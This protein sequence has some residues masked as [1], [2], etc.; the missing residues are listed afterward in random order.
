[1]PKKL[2]TSSNQRVDLDDFLRASNEYTAETIEFHRNRLWQAAKAVVASGFRIEIADQTANPGEFTVYNGVALNKDGAVLN[3]E[4]QENDSRTYTLSGTN[5]SFYIEIEFVE[6]TSDVDTRAFWDPTFSGNTPNGKEFDLNA[7]TRVTPDWQLVTPVSTTG[8]DVDTNINT[9]KIPIALFQTNGSNEITGA[10]T[11]APSSNLAVDTLVASSSLELIDTTIFP[12]TGTIVFPSTAESIAYN[13]ND[14]VNNILTLS[15]PTGNAYD[16]GVIVQQDGVVPDML[17]ESTDPAPTT[18]SDRRRSFFKG[19]ENRGAALTAS[20]ESATARDD[21]DLQS[22]KD[23]IDFYA[24]QLREMKWGNLRSDKSGITVPPLSFTDTRYYDAAGSIQGAKQSLITIG[25]GSYTYGDL[26]STS[27]DLGTIIQQAHDALDATNGG[28]IYVKAGD[29]VWDAA[30]TVDRPFS[31]EFDKGVNFVAGTYTTY[32]IFPGINNVS[33]EI[34]GMPAGPTTSDLLGIADFTGYAVDLTLKD[35]TIGYLSLTLGG[36][37]TTIIA[38]NCDFLDTGLDAVQMGVTRRTELSVFRNCRFLYV[39]ESSDSPRQL[40]S[41]CSDT[42]F[43]DCIFDLSNAAAFSK[44]KFVNQNMTSIAPGRMTFDRCSFLST[45]TGKAV[46]P[47]RFVSSTFFPGID[48]IAFRDCIFDFEFGTTAN[49]TDRTVLNFDISSGAGTGPMKNIL[50]ENCDFSGI[51]ENNTIAGTSIVDPYR[52]VSFVSQAPVYNVVVNNC[53]FGKEINPAGATSTLPNHYTEFVYLGI[54]S[55]EGSGVTISNN[56]FSTFSRA[57][58]VSGDGA[59]SVVGNYFRQKAQTAP[60]GDTIQ[61]IYVIGVQEQALISGNQIDML[62]F[63]TGASDAVIG[64]FVTE[65]TNVTIVDNRIRVFDFYTVVA[66]ATVYGIWGSTSADPTQFIVTGNHVEAVSAAKAIQPIDIS[67]SS[68]TTS[69]IVVSDNIVSAQALSVSI[70]NKMVGIEIVSDTIATSPSP[71]SVSG[72]C[73]RFDSGGV[74]VTLPVYGISIF[75]DHVTVVGN[76]I[77]MDD[78]GATEVVG[79]YSSSSEYLTI[80][81]NHVSIEDSAAG[82][83]GIRGIQLNND[84]SY[85]N[86][87]GNTIYGEQ[88]MLWCIEVDVGSISEARSIT[89]ANNVMDGSCD[90]TVSKHGGIHFVTTNVTVGDCGAWNITGNS[91]YERISNAGDADRKAIYVEG[92]LQVR[93]VNVIGNSNG[94]TFTATNRSSDIE[95]DTCSYV[96]VSN[97]ICERVASNSGSIRI[98]LTACNSITLNGNNVPYSAAIGFGAST[99]WITG[100]ISGLYNNNQSVGGGILINGGAADMLSGGSNHFAVGVLA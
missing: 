34:I 17:V 100:G 9:V 62:T 76:S 67:T 23:Q 78:V 82:L 32:A 51:D 33:M 80:S 81:G 24:A 3:N 46:E 59:F 56:S 10:T 93:A 75:G 58:N 90:E 31:L 83:N 85:S 88:D 65:G 87:S 28:S 94:D 96:N 36:A 18:G 84:C 95:V 50:I 2:N 98:T 66:T 97:N 69:A 26:N 52:A 35:C 49:V 54:T 14:R 7:A 16:L 72:N 25:D 6:S 77:T 70:Y 42:T 71:V 13:N 15:V 60:F 43:E 40:I 73:V 63:E 8:F 47:F 91:F 64:I 74:A 30:V 29:Y 5:L 11:S 20:K 99:L 61:A 4:A 21:L 48:G 37:D 57:V 86:I 39:N 44:E 92:T 45:N 22:L 55:T 53:K 68:G 19:D 38:D 1:M 12:D 27:D 89:V 41:N 79:I